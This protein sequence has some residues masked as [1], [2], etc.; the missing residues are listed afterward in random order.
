MVL[1]PINI[2]DLAT[3]DVVRIQLASG[4]VAETVL[5]GV[6]EVQRCQVGRPYRNTIVIGRVMA[7]DFQARTL[8]VEYND[9]TLPE[10]HFQ[11]TVLYKQ[12]RV[13][14]RQLPGT[15]L[16]ANRRRIPCYAPVLGVF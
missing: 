3:T 15:F 12:I 6:A 11:V 16:P 8:V 7:N 1:T 13:I 4:Y 14:E 2:A 5:P 9:L 10:H